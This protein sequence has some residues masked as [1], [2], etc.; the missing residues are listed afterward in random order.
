MISIMSLKNWHGKQKN[1]GV[2]SGG[3][4]SLIIL[5]SIIQNMLTALQDSISAVPVQ[6]KKLVLM[7]NLKG[8]AYAATTHKF[9]VT[10]KTLVRPR[11]IGKIV[12]IE[13]LR[14]LVVLIIVLIIYPPQTVLR[15]SVNESTGDEGIKLTDV[16]IWHV[17]SNS[18][19]DKV[20]DRT[21]ELGVQEVKTLEASWFYSNNTLESLGLNEMSLV[22]FDGYWIAEQVNNGNVHRFLRESSRSVL[23]F[24]AIG[25]PTSKFLEVIDNA[26]IEEMSHEGGRVSG[27]QPGDPLE[28]AFGLKRIGKPDDYILCPFIYVCDFEDPDRMILGLIECLRG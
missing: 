9:L 28:I 11:K 26:R 4:M 19:L 8:G 16:T 14:I 25:G 13:L 21:R 10:I 5:K 6:A 3:K 7:E 17:G 24:V 2:A 20:L 18:L 23:A 1:A 15:P 12:S 27:T 22:V